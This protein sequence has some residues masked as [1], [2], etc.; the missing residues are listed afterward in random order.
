LRRAAA[1]LVYGVQAWGAR[2]RLCHVADVA[3]RVCDRDA[4]RGERAVA[5]VKWST[6][7]IAFGTQLRSI[8]RARSMPSL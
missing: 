8:F 7:R 2:R 5:V 6:S 4:W 1:V 3:E